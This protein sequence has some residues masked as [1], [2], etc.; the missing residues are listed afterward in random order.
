MSSIEDTKHDRIREFKHM[1]DVKVAISHNNTT[2]VP[3]RAKVHAREFVTANKPRAV[4]Q[5]IYEEGFPIETGAVI[6]CLYK[7]RLAEYT[8]L[9]EEE[10]KYHM[11]KEVNSKGDGVLLT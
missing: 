3:M 7:S 10:D 2:L 1:Y 11:L 9:M 8:Q 4:V 5:K 6:K